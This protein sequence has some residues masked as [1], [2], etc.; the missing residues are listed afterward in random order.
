MWASGSRQRT[1]WVSRSIPTSAALPL[2]CRPLVR[3]RKLPT[4]AAVATRRPRPSASYPRSLLPSSRR[5]F[6]CCSKKA[7][8]QSPLLIRSRPASSTSTG[9]SRPPPQPS[10]CPSPPSPATIS[11]RHS[12]LKLAAY[13]TF[14]DHSPV[15]QFTNFTATQALLDEIGGSTSSCIH[16]IDFDLGVGGQ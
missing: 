7:S 12:S 15:L 5:R 14:S 13:K 6:R 10:S 1:L 11:R 16:V 8:T 2:T 3:C 4:V 9:T